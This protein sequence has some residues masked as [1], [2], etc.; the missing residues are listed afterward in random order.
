MPRLA[1]EARIKAENI[2]E[3]K[4]NTDAIEM[5]AKEIFLESVHEM[6][7]LVADQLYARYKY[8][9]TALARQFPFMMGNDVWKGGGNLNP[10][11]EVGRC[12]AQR[13]IR[14]WLH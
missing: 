12:I 10:N 11:E 14:Y 3:D 7:T 9:R 13:Y 6:A 1:I 5:K 2:I 4:R 8:Q